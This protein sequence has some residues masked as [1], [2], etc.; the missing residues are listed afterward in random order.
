M[1][2]NVD[3][4]S[5]DRKGQVRLEQDGSKQF[6]KPEAASD[7]CFEINGKDS[8]LSCDAVEV[9]RER[10]KEDMKRCRDRRADDGDDSILIA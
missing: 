2:A 5:C 1:A 10:P 9:Y 7:G 4:A 3:E 6:S 8:N